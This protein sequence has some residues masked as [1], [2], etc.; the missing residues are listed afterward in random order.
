MSSKTNIEWTDVTWNPVRGCALVSAGCQHC[1]AM[2]QAHRFSGKAQPYE[3]LTE[4]G[5]Q[6][7]R[8]NGTIRLVPEALEAPLHWHQRR[9]VFVNSMSDLF[10]EDISDEFIAAVFGIMCVASQHTYQILTKRPARMQQWCEWLNAHGGLVDFIA[11]RCDALYL[12][13]LVAPGSCAGI[14]WRGLPERATWPLPNVWLGVSVEDQ[15]TADERIP[16]LL[17]TPA[18]VRFI[19][20]EPVLGPVSLQ[21]WISLCRADLVTDEYGRYSEVRHQTANEMR[22]F[23]RREAWAIHWVIVGGESGSGARPCDVAWIR[24]IRDQ[25]GEAGVP[26]FV[27]QLGKE[28]RGLCEWLHHEQYPAEWLDE[29]GTLLSVSGA[30]VGDLCH[31][32][33]DWWWPCKPTLKDK[34]GGDMAEWPADLRVR[35]YPRE[36]P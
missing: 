1:Y 17:Q 31:A 26:V 14:V 9:R 30:K 15:A 3:G 12:G 8:W 2:K 7:P 18:A 4:V 21:P 19:S 29:N 28:P 6:G 25:C 35:Q 33:D 24:S 36:I 22:V 34:K 23:S 5:P 27:K 20:A 16:I 10:H 32:M 11:N 13:A